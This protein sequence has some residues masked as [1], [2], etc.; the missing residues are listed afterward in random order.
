M[1]SLARDKREEEVCSLVEEWEGMKRVFFFVVATES[2]W[3]RMDIDGE[4]V[5][6][7]VVVTEGKDVV[8]ECQRLVGFSFF[9]GLLMLV[10]SL[11]AG[12]CS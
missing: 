4:V 9:F 3:G 11:F 10:S 6:V 5:E 1:C 2:C 12:L 7:A 8:V